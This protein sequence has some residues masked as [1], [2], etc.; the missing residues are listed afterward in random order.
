[1]KKYLFLTFLCCFSAICA[2]QEDWANMRKYAAQNDSIHQG[3]LP[4]PEVVFFGNSITEFWKVHHPSFFAEHP[5]FCCRGISGQTTHQLL[6][7]LREDVINLAPKKVVIAIGINDIAQNTKPYVE[8]YSLGYIYDMAELCRLH[9]IEVYIASLLPS[10]EAYWNPSAGHFLP[11]VRSFNAALQAYCA[12]QHLTYVN[13]YPAFEGTDGFINPALA[14]DGIHPNVP[15]YEVME[16]IVL[17]AL[18][19]E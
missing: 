13:Y 8:A 9:G 7:R 6:L 11:Q 1:M 14:P 5:T 4:Q 12:E 10:D 3:L 19:M 15:G 17:S 16:R 2:A 18:G